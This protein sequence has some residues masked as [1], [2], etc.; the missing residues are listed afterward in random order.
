MT[1]SCVIVPSY[2]ICCLVVPFGLLVPDRQR[3][4]ANNSNN[5]NND[6]DNNNND[7]DNKHEL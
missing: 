7:N 1:C 5:N 4:E 6:N 3:L 2:F